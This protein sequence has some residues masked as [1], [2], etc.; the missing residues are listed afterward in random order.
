MNRI[1]SAY[2]VGLL[3]GLIIGLLFPFY[4][5]L[6]GSDVPLYQQVNILWLCFGVII[7]LCIGI[8]GCVYE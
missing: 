7:V 4:C 5:Y 3:F 2:V 1:Q 6:F 8:V